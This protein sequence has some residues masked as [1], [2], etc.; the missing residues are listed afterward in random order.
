MGAPDLDKEVVLLVNAF[1]GLT[2]L[3]QVIVTAASA[4]VRGGEGRYEETSGIKQRKGRMSVYTG[5]CH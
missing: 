1:L 5:V 3:A 2:E 4:A